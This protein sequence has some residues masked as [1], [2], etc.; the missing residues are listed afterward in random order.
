MTFGRSD[1]VPPRGAAGC[2]HLTNVKAIALALTGAR[3]SKTQPSAA[4]RDASAWVQQAQ[5]ALEL[6]GDIKFGLFAQGG[7]ARLHPPLRFQGDT[8]D[9]KVQET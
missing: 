4:A 9:S 2:A 8:A 7:K 1:P 3:V 6:Q 5:L